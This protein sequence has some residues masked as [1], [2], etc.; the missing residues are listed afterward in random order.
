[1]QL[2]VARLPDAEGFSFWPSFSFSVFGQLLAGSV[3]HSFIARHF[4]SILAFFISGFFYFFGY[5]S[6]NKKASMH[7]MKNYKEFLRL[8]LSTTLRRYRLANRLFLSLS[9]S[10]SLSLALLYLD[11]AYYIIER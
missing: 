6:M 5:T 11:Y 8:L 9:L 1:M 2:V 10:L 3:E 7:F 4:L